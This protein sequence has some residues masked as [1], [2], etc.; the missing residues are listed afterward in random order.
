MGL[1]RLFKV[2]NLILYIYLVWKHSKKSLTVSVYTFIM[3]VFCVQNCCM[4]FTVNE[5]TAYD[6]KSQL[7]ALS[8]NY[9][10]NHCWY[11][12]I[13]SSAFT[14]ILYNIYLLIVRLKSSHIKRIY[15]KKIYYI[16]YTVIGKEDWPEI[17]LYSTGI[18]ILWPSICASYTHKP[19]QKHKIVPLYCC[20]HNALTI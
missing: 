1:A 9:I 17:A 7:E 4:C 20:V 13:I 11:L 3:G 10:L 6:K 12:R 5:N 2:Y 14:H 8:L 19:T 18:I 15:Q 16:Q